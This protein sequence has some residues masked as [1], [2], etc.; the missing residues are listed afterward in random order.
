[1]KSRVLLLAAQKYSLKDDRTGR[2]IAGVSLIYSG[3]E[4]SKDPDEKGLKPVKQSADL[5]VWPSIRD[6]PGFYEM[7]FA[8]ATT[9]D[10]QGNRIPTMK[11]VALDFVG[12]ITVADPAAKS[13]I[14]NG[15]VP[16]AP[17]GAGRS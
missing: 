13:S 15:S 6:V 9:T 2:E 7:D 1:M 16:P 17:V 14:S 10:K 3:G 8:L 4:V 5:A 12:G 11:P